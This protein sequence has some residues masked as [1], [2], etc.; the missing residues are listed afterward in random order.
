MRKQI[1]PDIK[2]KIALEA[3]REKLTWAQICSKYKVSN[4]QIQKFKKE[5]EKNIL[6]GF[7]AKQD[8]QIQL[9]QDKIDELLKLVGQA[10]LEN[11][12]LKK[13]LKGIID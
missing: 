7:S 9:Q 5:A 8:K 11:A 6:S 10:Q 1:S 12:W 3:I 13:K 4:P 2:L